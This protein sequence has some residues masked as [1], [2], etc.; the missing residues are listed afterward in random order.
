MR[1]DIVSEG[2]AYFGV[3]RAFELG[4]VNAR[5]NGTARV[6]QPLGTEKRIPLV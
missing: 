3:E 1:T 6:L 2:V 4:S 5:A